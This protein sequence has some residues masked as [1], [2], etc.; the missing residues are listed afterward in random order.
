MTTFLNAARQVSV[1]P[2]IDLFATR[3]NFKIKPF[4]SPCPDD[5]AWAM[6]ATTLDW[7]EWDSIYLFPPRPLLVHLLPK[8]ASFKGVGLLIAFKT[9]GSLVTTALELRC[10]RVFR[11]PSPVLSQEKEAGV[12]LH[13]HVQSLQLHAWFL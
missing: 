10:H 13:D 1:F 3:Y 6:D 8:I 2:Q 5:E 11:L 4:V 7:N 12:V 9:P